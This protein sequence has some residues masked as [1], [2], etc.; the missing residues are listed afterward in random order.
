MRTI[1]IKGRLTP[2]KTLAAFVDA[3]VEDDASASTRDGYVQDVRGF[4]T[5]YG[6]VEARRSP[7]RSVRAADLGSYRNHLL[8][9]ER[10][11]GTTVNRKLQALKRFYRFVL[12]AGWRKDDPTRKTKS[13]RTGKRLRPVELSKKEETALLRAASQS[14]RGLGAR[15]YALVQLML[16]AGLRVSE[17][18]RLKL[19][20]V[21]LRLRSGEVVVRDGKGHRQRVVPLN[22]AARR[23]LNRYLE[24]RDELDEDA[25]LFASERG[26][27]L[28][29][30]SIQHA[31][32]VSA[33][34]AGVERAVGAH[35]LRHTFAAR[36]IEDHPDQLVALST[37][38]GH[39]SL[40]TTA[41]YVRP[42][43]RDLARRLERT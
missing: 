32:S 28:S 27:Q 29:L 13:M 30:R 12:D 23:G 1:R 37:L 38:L 7:I 31:V 22:V 35:T 33:E 20:D 3:L 4:F 8:D 2:E 6:T 10:R 19:A 36:F 11:K 41:I 34:R 26:A 17:V 15:N 43:S 9:V 40:D 14:P 16:Q 24:T 25:P 18:T 21:T 39:E 42:S 5:W